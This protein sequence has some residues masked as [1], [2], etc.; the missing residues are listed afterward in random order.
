M[1]IRVVVLSLVIALPLPAAEPPVAGTTGQATTVPVS[2]LNLTP[3][4]AASVATPATGLTLFVDASG[5][6]CVKDP[7]GAVFVVELA[8]V[9]PKTPAASP[10]PAKPGP[11][12][13]S[14]PTAAPKQT[15]KPIPDPPPVSPPTP[16]PTAALLPPVDRPLLGG[17]KVTNPFGRGCI[18][19]DWSS[20]TLAVGGHGQENTL[21]LYDLPAMGSGTDPQTWPVLKPKEKVAAFWP[22]D[23]YPS[24]LA[25]WNGDWWVSPR[26]TYDTSPPADQT[27]YSRKGKT[28]HFKVPRQSFNGMVK[29]FGKDPMPGGGGTESGQ[30]SAHG[31]T[32]ASADGKKLITH[33]YSAAFEKREW[34]EPNYWPIDH[35]DSWV[36]CEPRT[37]YGRKV[38]VWAC[39][40]IYAGGLILDD[41]VHYWPYMGVGDISYSRQN[42]TFAA[43]NK[44]YE[45]RYDTDYKLIGWSETEFGQ[46]LGQEFGPK[47]E[48]VL[49]EGGVW[50]SE[51]YQ[52]DPVIRVYGKPKPATK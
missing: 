24:G 42:D 47:G 18:A 52:V 28:L 34:R 3:V 27:W 25:W 16:A 51:L 38:G 31:P 10:A 14:T 41:G 11:A 6:L 35:K 1:R 36:A 13:A 50:K 12:P 32:L 43:K 7:S 23:C 21:L 37:V 49:A 30:G 19:I 39:D 40:Q 17:W 8:V 2:G 20:N 29:T 15:P 9:A 22:A 45:Y 46:I 26:K 4:P 48:V 44:T 33:D 5:K